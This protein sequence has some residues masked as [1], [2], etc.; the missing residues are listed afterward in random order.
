VQTL[1]ER[2][3]ETSHLQ[4]EIWREF[5]FAML[6]FLIAEGILLLPANPKEQT[7]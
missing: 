2:H 3:F 6:V 7:A 5:V 1:Q 4:G